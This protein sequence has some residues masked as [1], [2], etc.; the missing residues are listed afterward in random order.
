MRRSRF[1]GGRTDAKPYGRYSS[2]CQKHNR[3]FPTYDTCRD[4]ARD[5]YEAEKERLARLADTS[6]EE[7]ERRSRIKAATDAMAGGTPSD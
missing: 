2:F 3:S 4:C 7:Q 5:R 6:A 1:H